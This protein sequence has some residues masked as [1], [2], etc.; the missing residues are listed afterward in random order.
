MKHKLILTLAMAMASSNFC[1]AAN[2]YAVVVS[3]ATHA[4]KDWKPV[5]TALVEKHGAKVIEFE[6]NVTGTLGKLRGQFPSSHLFCR[7]AEGG[8]GGFRGRRAS[9]HARAG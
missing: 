9:A 6:G 7:Y 4:D 3:K 1:F 8:D 2:D 5:V